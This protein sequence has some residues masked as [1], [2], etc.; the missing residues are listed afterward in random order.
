MIIDWNTI[1]FVIFLVLSSF[2]IPYFLIGMVFWFRR[3]F[4][5]KLDKN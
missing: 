2:L 1:L 4:I 5:L 3:K